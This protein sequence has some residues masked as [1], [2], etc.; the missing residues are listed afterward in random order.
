MSSSS[1]AIHQFVHTLSYGDAIS[2]EALAL[3]RCAHEMGL[4]S[5]IYAINIDPKYKS[6]AHKYTIFNAEQESDVILHYSLGSPL[7]DLYRKLSSHRRILVYHNL[8]PAKWFSGVN[9]RI[10]KDILRGLEELPELCRI[11]DN[12]WADSKFNAHE[13]QNL[14]FTADVLELPVDPSR[15]SEPANSGIASLVKGEGGV[16]VL[17]VGRLAPNKCIE[18]IIRAF[19]FLHHYIDPKSRLWLVGIDIDTELYSFSLKRLVYE[20]SLSDAVNF[21]GRFADCEVRALYENASVYLCMS[22]HE[23]FCMP[24]VEAMYFGLPV[25]AYSSSA[26]TDTVGAG[27]IL[28]GEKRPA[29]V[30]ELLHRVATDHELRTK[31]ISA[32]KAR[33]E[34]LSYARFAGRLKEL[35]EKG[36]N[37]QLSPS[38]RVGM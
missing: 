31:L 19:Y 18:D 28:L 37:R 6:L 30:G 27:G 2:G 38:S 8:T 21:V 35:L 24:V 3:R 23:G 1:R 36:A 4:K 9:P 7:N 14:G 15:W 10:V 13:L 12:L 16:Q 11:S 32:G 22:E 26:L 34:S 33:V 17:H 29:E 20:L 25:V 5:E